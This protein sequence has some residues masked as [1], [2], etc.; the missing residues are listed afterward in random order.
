MSQVKGVV[1]YYLPGMA[2]SKVMFSQEH[3]Q[4]SGHD[5]PTHQIG[6]KMAEREPV[7]RRVVTLSKNVTKGANTHTHFARITINKE[8]KVVK[9]AV[10]R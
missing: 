2:G 7:T 5:C 1:K 8:G 3:V 9:L 6:A 10:S 4:C